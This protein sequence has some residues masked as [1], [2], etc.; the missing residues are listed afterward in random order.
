MK[1]PHMVLVLC[2]L[3]VAFVGAQLYS[4]AVNA[5]LVG[6]VS[7]ASG[8]VV[9]GAKVT[10][11]EVQTGSI[12]TNQTNEGGNYVFP[13]LPPGKYSLTVE[14]AGFKKETRNNIDILVDTTPRVDFQL[15]PGNVSETVEVKATP[16]LLQTD[17]VDTGAK[18]DTAQ[19]ADMPLGVNRNFQSLLNLVPGTTPATFDHS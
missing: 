10:L 18:M 14:Q 1:H 3:T 9:P 15:Q 8:A 19:V 4:Q 5:T 17:S 2:A 16:A 6:N 12:R 13:D 7:D 11:T